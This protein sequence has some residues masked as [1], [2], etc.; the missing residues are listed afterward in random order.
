MSR[1]YVAGPDIDLDVEVVRDKKGRRISQARAE[2]VAAE[3][4]DSVVIGRAVADRPRHALAGG[5]KPR[6]GRAPRPPREGRRRARH[7]PFGADSGRVG[8]LP[9][10]L[11]LDSEGRARPWP[12]PSEG[13][14]FVVV[15]RH[16]RADVIEHLAQVLVAD[17]ITHRRAASTEGLRSGATR[18]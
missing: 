11:T 18:I 7:Q 5:K 4:L 1:K 3:A 9:R 17:S 10:S 2:Q 13:H 12:A 16:H 6:A 14:Y 15:L 8:A